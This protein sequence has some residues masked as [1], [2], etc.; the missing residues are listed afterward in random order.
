MND[1]G[2]CNLCSMNQAEVRNY[3]SSNASN[4]DKKQNTMRCIIDGWTCLHNACYACY[5]SAYDLDNSAHD[6][7]ISII[8]IGGSWS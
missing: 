2:V 8:D 7:V 1:N 4:E 3:L 6:L 5:N